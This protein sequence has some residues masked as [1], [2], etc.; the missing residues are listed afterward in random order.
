M[1]LIFVFFF[2]C[3]QCQMY[4]F[5]DVSN[6]FYIYE[7]PEEYWWRWPKASADCKSQGYI[8]HE[9]SLNSGIG[10]PI[11]LDSGL[12]LTWHFSLFSS[13]Y[14]R[15]KRSSRRTLDP[16]VDYIAKAFENNLA[17]FNTLES[18]NVY[19]TL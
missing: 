12:F 11:D 3:F 8:S 15:M 19:N 14:N 10:P 18:K 17:I 2:V 9:H 5:Q 4:G 7:L 13:L 6:L 1:H 16:E